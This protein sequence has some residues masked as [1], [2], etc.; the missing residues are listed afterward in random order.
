MPD[1]DGTEE[2]LQSLPPGMAW[3]YAEYKPAADRPSLRPT[4]VGAMTSS[5]TTAAGKRWP[6]GSLL[7]FDVVNRPG[8]HA[9]VLFAASPID[10]TICEAASAL[11]VPADLRLGIDMRRERA[12]NPTVQRFDELAEYSARAAK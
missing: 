2:P 11:R 3:R 7:V 8:N 5:S 10:G 12:R 9:A 6:V 1:R 4:N